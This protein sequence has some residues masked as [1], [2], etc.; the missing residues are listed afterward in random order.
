MQATY[1]VGFAILVEAILSFLGVGIPTDIPTWGNIMAEGRLLFRVYPHAILFPG[2]FLALAVLAINVLGDGLRDTLDPRFAKRTA[3]MTRATPVLDIRG[4]TVSLPAGADR[5]NAV[6]AIDL[7]VFPK[8]IVCVV[9]ESG[10]GKSVTAH[11]VMGL[12][13]KTELRPIKGSI[14]LADEPLLEKTPAEL[15]Q[16]RGARMSMIFQEPFTA[17]NPV[18]RVGEQIEEVL[19]I[20]TDMSAAERRTRVLDVMRD[21]RLPEPERLIDVYPHQLSGGQRQ[22]IMIAAALALEPALLIADEPTTAL[23]VTT[24]A[25]ILTLIKDIQAS[26]ETGVL[27]ITH[28]FGVVAD[29]ADRVV[30]MQRGRI[31]EAGAA[32]RVLTAPEHPYTQMLIGSV[33]SLIA[34]GA[35]TRSQAARPGAGDARPR[36]DLSQRRPFSKDARGEGGARRDHRPRARR[37]ARHRRRERLRQVDGR[38]LHRPVDRPDRRRHPDRRRGHRRPARAAPARA[39]AKSADRLPGPLPLA[40]SQAH[41]SAARSSKAR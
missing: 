18:M 30:V 2:I 21:V 27:F 40:Q 22:R 3:D 37:D 28:D 25:Q 19:T 23:D 33:P 4:L 5:P 39:S 24:Q 9:G 16:L 20:H 6:E 35:R 12:L 13:P 7:Q 29:I 17:L 31:V 34:E 1:T 38:A 10:S 8:E 11:A 41:V 26:H 36:K 15:R 14:R 32:G